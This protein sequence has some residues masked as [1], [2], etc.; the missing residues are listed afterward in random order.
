M[1]LLP[2][3]DEVRELLRETGVEL[4]WLPREDNLAGKVLEKGAI[5]E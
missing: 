5:N 2:L 4:R 1:H 3:R